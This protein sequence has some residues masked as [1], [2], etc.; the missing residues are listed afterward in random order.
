MSASYGAISHHETEAL[1]TSTEVVS[2]P[3]SSAGDYNKFAT[4][5]IFFFPA[6]GG[7]LFGF[8]IGATSAVVTQLA[9]KSY[10]GTTWYDFSS[11]V[12]VCYRLFR[13]I[14]TNWS[15]TVLCCKDR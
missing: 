3:A 12:S 15:T 10:S 11:L 4:F 1:L 2:P 14:G 13:L 5:L 7:L 9:S 6:L 8:D